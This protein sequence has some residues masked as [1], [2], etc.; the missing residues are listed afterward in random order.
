MKKLTLEQFNKKY[1]KPNADWEFDKF[2]IVCVKCGSN[3]VEYNGKM[4]TEYGYY[5]SVDVTLRIVIKCHDCGNAFEISTF[6]GGSSDCY[7]DCNR[8]HSD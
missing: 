6:G 3:K 4:E 5:G 2:K 7:V 8:E 1:R